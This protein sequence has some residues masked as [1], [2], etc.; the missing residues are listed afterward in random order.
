MRGFVFVVWTCCSILAM[1]DD[2]PW[3]QF[4]GPRGDGSSLATNL[5]VKFAE[6]SPEIIWKTAIAGRAWSS[7]VVWDDQIWLTNGP[8]IQNVTPEQPK[9][10]APIQLRAVCVDL[11]SGDIVASVLKRWYPAHRNV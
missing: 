8:E 4:R 2:K 9:L 6:G 1:A 10:D 5:P 11:A 7:P 3:N